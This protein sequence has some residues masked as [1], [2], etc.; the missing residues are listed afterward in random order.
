MKQ[1]FTILFA[2]TIL[3]SAQ[4][5]KAAEPQFKPHWYMQLQGGGAYTLGESDFGDMLSPAAALSVGRNFNPIWGLRVGVSGWQAKGAWFTPIQLYKFNF[6]QVNAD[7]TVDISNWLGG[8]KYDRVVNPYVFLGLGANI[9]FNNDEAKRISESGNTLTLLWTGNKAF[10]AGRA[11]A[12]VNF[13]LSK[14]VQIGVEV[15]T[16]MLPDKFNSKNA[17]NLDWHTNA[18]V[19]LAFRFGNKDKKAAASTFVPVPQAKTA[20][21]APV[22]TPAPA[23]KAE[24]APEPI[25]EKPTPVVR[26][27][28]PAPPAAD[29][30]KMRQDIYFEI[31][32]SDIKTSENDKLDT[33][34]KYLK[35]NPKVRISIVGYADA[36]TGT[37]KGNYWLSGWRAISVRDALK[38]QG[39][40]ASRIVMDF[41]G[42]KE[43]PYSDVEDNRVV[44]CIIR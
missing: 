11:G 1:F 40:R 43:Q 19:G 30:Y 41:K 29:T 44:I 39:V 5:A 7:V 31:N 42:D 38:K 6:M 27:D 9:A 14:R 20:E 32:S 34:A 4:S 3:L 2:C 8:F 35:E 16:N 21:S 24:V 37:S 28:A 17:D 10:I 18:L 12:G 36:A 22:P 25:T 26:K 15:N 13:R 23:P 33:L